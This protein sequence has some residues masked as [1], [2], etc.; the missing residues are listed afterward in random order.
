MLRIA[1]IAAFAVVLM[2]YAFGTAAPLTLRFS[3]KP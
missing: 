1:L 3:K 2:P